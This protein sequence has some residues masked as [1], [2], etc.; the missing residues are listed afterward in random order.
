MDERE[1][2]EIILRV[3][4]EGGTLTL[5]RRLS[6]SSWQ[7]HVETDETALL[8]L[9]DEDDRQGLSK[10]ERPWVSDWLAAVAQLDEYQWFELTPLHIHP[11]YRQPIRAAVCERWQDQK[12]ADQWRADR[13]RQWND[14]LR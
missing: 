9:L 14:F 7:F 6:D 4:A 2:K 12:P 11:D 1:K 3:G 10:I 8:D 13:R 5:F